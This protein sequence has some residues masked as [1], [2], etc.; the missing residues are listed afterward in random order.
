MNQLYNKIAQIQSK[1]W[2]VLSKF[3]PKNSNY[4]TWDVLSDSFDKFQTFMYQQFG[5]NNK[6]NNDNALLIDDESNVLMIDKNVQKE[7][8]KCSLIVI[9]YYTDNCESC[10]AIL[11]DW[12]KL[13]MQ[14]ESK[15][16][17]FININC[18]YVTQISGK[19]G[20]YATPTYVL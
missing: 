2:D 1:Q 8:K 19:R 6:P 9:K 5:K 12:I 14:Y 16:V 17:L 11:R 18:V 20:V 3:R 4:I 10:K 7:D 13:S 15:S